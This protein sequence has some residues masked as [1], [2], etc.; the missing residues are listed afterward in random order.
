MAARHTPESFW[1]RASI[2]DGCWEYR[3]RLNRYGY[4]TIRYRGVQQSTHRL[5]WT[6]ARGSIPAGS[7]VLHH[8]DNPR[9][10]RPSHLFLGSHADNMADKCAKGR[11]ARGASVHRHRPP[12]PPVGERNPRAKLTWTAVAAIGEAIRGGATRAQVGRRFGVAPSTISRIATK[13]AWRRID[14]APTAAQ[15]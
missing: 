7:C 4:G 10:V 12:P 13:K 8:C 9:C 3:G 11:A 15:A 2:G 5:A 1:A 6:L 14:G